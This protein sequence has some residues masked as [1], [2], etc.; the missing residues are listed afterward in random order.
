MWSIMYY[1]HTHVLMYAACTYQI[2]IPSRT[3]FIIS[4]LL[5]CRSFLIQ[6]IKVF[7]TFW[8]SISQ[9]I[10][11]CLIQPST[12][13]CFNWATLTQGQ[14]LNVIDVLY[15]LILINFFQQIWHTWLFINSW[16]FWMVTVGPPTPPPPPNLLSIELN[17]NYTIIQY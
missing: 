8:C 14:C 7:T 15:F 6:I 1:A 16:S 10:I 5:C 12:Y 3:Y 13:F 11:L 4:C 9:F 2:I 17:L